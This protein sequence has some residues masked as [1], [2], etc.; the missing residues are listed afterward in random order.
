[1]TSLAETIGETARFPSDEGVSLLREA[2]ELLNVCF[3]RQEMTLEEQNQSFPDDGNDGVSLNQP[4][5]KN[6]KQGPS[7]DSDAEEQTVTVQEA[8]TPADLLDTARASLSALTLLVPLEEPTSL[9]TLASMAQTLVDSKIPQYLSQLPADEQ[10]K[11]GTE[12]ALERASFIAALA[13]AEYTAHTISCADYLSRLQ[14]FN[15]LELI[16]AVGNICTFA[17]SL[18]ELVT[19]IQAN[20]NSKEDIVSVSWTQLSKA[21]D[22]YGRAAKLDDAETRERKAVI[23]ES[24]GDVEMLR[25]R[26]ATSNLSGLA[27]SAKASAPLLIK[28]AQTYYR[29]STTLYN[30]AGDEFAANKARIRGLVAAVLQTAFARQSV[31]DKVVILKQQGALGREVVGDMLAEGLLAESP[32]SL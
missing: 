29:G 25:F 24:R 31:E 4:E 11:V 2:L 8:T 7:S 3:T 1:M 30:N 15:T 9:A 18:V 28:N 22:L 27:E 10:K 19:T 23:Y 13:A 26:L 17:D 32:L 12:I 20:A 21:Q 5:G 16:T 14:V 6:P